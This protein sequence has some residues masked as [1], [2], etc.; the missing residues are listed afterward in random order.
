MSH[1]F[2]EQDWVVADEA[3]RRRRGP[4][5]GD[6]VEMKPEEDHYF[7]RRNGG[8]RVHEIPTSRISCQSPRP[9]APPA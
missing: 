2:D 9:E 4:E 7:E 6:E 8:R 3:G 1:V 5:D